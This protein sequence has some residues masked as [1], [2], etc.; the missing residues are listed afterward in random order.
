MNNCNINNYDKLKQYLNAQARLLHL[1]IRIADLDLTQANA[2][3]QN[4]LDKNMHGSMQYL[5]TNAHIRNDPSILLPTAV[6]AIVARL[7]YSYLNDE[8]NKQNISKSIQSISTQLKQEQQ[9]LYDFK[10]INKHSAVI[11]W[12]AKGRDYHKVLRKQLGLLAKNMQKYIDDLNNNN[13]HNINFDYRI[14]TDSAPIMEVELAQKSGLGWRGKHT[15]LLNTQAGSL[16]FLGGMLTN[17]PFA[18]DDTIP[19]R[20]GTCSKCIQVCPTQAITAPYVLDARKCISYLTIEHDGGI[21]VEYRT[22][23][24][25]H[26]YGCDECQLVCPWN[27]FAQ[28]SLIADFKPRNYPNSILDLWLWN[29]QVFLHKTEG[30]AIRRIGYQK[31]RRNLIIVMGN[32]M[33]ELKDKQYDKQ[34]ITQLL[35]Q[36]L[37]TITNQNNENS[38]NILKE[39]VLWA[40]KQ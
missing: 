23:I 1:E 20:C 2:H 17:I 4:W 39:H 36:E 7:N 22:L 34:H 26:V 5:K 13:E 3:L 15:L 31:W 9:N 37:S 25:K 38:N 28:K 29:E 32:Y 40:L 10:D 12:Y 24:G 8:D 33:R 16:F 35:S 11:S 27:K 30:S 14:F 18:V 19:N 6:R 21:P